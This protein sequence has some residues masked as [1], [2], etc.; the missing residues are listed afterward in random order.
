MC[1]LTQGEFRRTET[2]R[3]GL[4]VPA[5]AFC[6]ALAGLSRACRLPQAERGMNIP[7]EWLP[8]L[9]QDAMNQTGPLGENPRPVT[10]KDALGSY[11]AA[12]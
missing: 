7:R 5:A 8:A 6:S 4:T 2:G 12:C 1:S 10:E 9:A 3:I 11:E